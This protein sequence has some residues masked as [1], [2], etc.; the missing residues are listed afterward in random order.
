MLVHFPGIIDECAFNDVKVCASNFCLTF[1]Q[2]SQIL[3]AMR[4]LDF[5]SRL[6]HLPLIFRWFAARVYHNDATFRLSLRSVRST[7][8]LT[9]GTWLEFM[10][11][12]NNY[13]FTVLSHFQIETSSELS[14]DNH[15]PGSWLLKCFSVLLSLVD[16]LHLVKL[17]TA[18]LSNLAQ[19]VSILNIFFQN[20][21]Y[22]RFFCRY[23]DVKLFVKLCETD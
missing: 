22:N 5:I 7:K 1:R 8:H 17:N 20:K 9:Y 19:P 3:K 10:P 12:S 13:P 6:Y 16:T 23:L 14:A 21:T 4:G 18:F 15:N 11:V 2:K